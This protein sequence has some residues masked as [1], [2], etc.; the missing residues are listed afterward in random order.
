MEYHSKPPDAFFDAARAALERLREPADLGALDIDSW[1]LVTGGSPEDRRFEAVRKTFLLALALLRQA[2]NEAADLLDAVYWQGSTLAELALQTSVSEATIYRRRDRARE[3]LIQILW[4]MET[5]CRQE[6][7]WLRVLR[8]IGAKRSS[9]IGTALLLVVGL[10]LLS[11][12]VRL[13]LQQI[14]LDLMS[15]QPL[16]CPVDSQM[17]LIPAGGFLYGS[18]VRD[19][20]YIDRIL[21]SDCPPNDTNCVTGY[22]D[23]EIPQV[24]LELSEY[25]M[26]VNEVSNEHFAE[27]VQETRFVTSAERQGSSTVWFESKRDMFDVEGAS[28]RQP[29]GPGSGGLEIQDHPA[30]HISVDDAQ[31]YCAWRGARLPTRWEWEKAAR[32]T[33]GYRFPWGHKWDSSRLN[34]AD[35]VPAMTR[36][37]GSYPSGESPFGLMDMLGNVTEWVLDRESTDNATERRGGGFP[38]KGLYSHVAWHSIQERDSTNSWGGFRCARSTERAE[39]H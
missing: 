35:T 24:S 19:L 36:P 32:G 39:S 25:C 18:T 30:V 22:F 27:F 28:W 15:P 12:D 16:P 26:D 37:V 23:D 20:A 10:L 13:S 8:G 2:D 11:Q 17:V 29:S 33:S 9:I 3:H 31:A 1:C 34:F 21:G 7:Q 14:A 6:S 5:R 38:T 4:E